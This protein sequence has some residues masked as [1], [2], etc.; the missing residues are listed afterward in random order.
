MTV[1]ITINGPDGP[2]DVDVP[3]VGGEPVVIPLVSA[4]IERSDGT[5][6]LQKRAKPGESA[7]GRWELPGGRWTAGESAA[8]VVRREVN[9]ETGM[10]VVSVFGSHEISGDLGRFE[11]LAPDLVITGHGGAFPLHVTVLRV[12]THGSP[13]PLEGET[14]DPTWMSRRE[15]A[16]LLARNRNA[17]VPIVAVILDAVFAEEES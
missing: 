5:I 13:R 2:L 12:E 14:S 6:F 17:F 1:S 8:T 9:E 4:L 10:T 15:V 7:F 3:S 11:L 16:A